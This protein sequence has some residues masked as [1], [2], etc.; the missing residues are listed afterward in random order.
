MKRVLLI[1]SCALFSVAINAQNTNP[2][3]GV[4]WGLSF[5][6]HYSLEEILEHVGD[7][8]TYVNSVGDDSQQAYAF[9]NA[10]FESVVFDQ[11]FFIAAN[12][13]ELNYAVFINS[14][15]DTHTPASLADYYSK[16]LNEFEGKYEHSSKTDYLDFLGLEECVLFMNYTDR[17]AALLA[18]NSAS[19]Q[20]SIVGVAF[21]D[22]ES[23]LGDRA[24]S[25]LPDLQ[26]TFFEQ[27]LGEK[28]N[29]TKIKA[30]VGQKGEYVMTDDSDTDIIYSFDDLT[31]GGNK[32]DT[33]DFYVTKE[34]YF[35]SFTVSTSFRDSFDD[36]NTG[37]KLYESFKDKLQSKYGE[38]RVEEEIDDYKVTFNGKNGIFAY[39]SYS[40]S[41]AN[42]GSYRYYVTI[43]YVHNRLLGE[44]EAAEMDEL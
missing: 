18:R 14:A 36:R 25:R 15:S 32:W 38:G 33:G 28:T 19:E 5:G 34:G 13:P 22:M 24:P 40:R 17:I 35:Y 26:D 16:M 11:L 37:K 44:L 42:N 9:S 43:D 7:A 3:E 31:F 41:Q 27:K 12:G 8:A 29:L 6:K 10:M 2:Y 4:F 39:I 1:I 23:L 21:I 20:L 30:A